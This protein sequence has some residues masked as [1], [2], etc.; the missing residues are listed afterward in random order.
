MGDI[1]TSGS[2]V[3]A[4]SVYNSTWKV[5]IYYIK[6]KVLLFSNSYSIAVALGISGSIAIYLSSFSLISH[7]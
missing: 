7:F 3:L 1:F 6:N 4:F 2:A 5:H